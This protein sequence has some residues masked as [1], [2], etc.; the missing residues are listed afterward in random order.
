MLEL[1][2]TKN[3]KNL[4]LQIDAKIPSIG[5]CTLRGFSGSGKSTIL[6]CISGKLN[7][8]S[9]TIKLENTTSF[10]AEKGINHAPY[11]RNFGF[12][13]QDGLLFPNLNVYENLLFGYK[14]RGGNKFIE[15]DEIVEILGIL[16]LLNRNIKNLSGGEKQRIALGRALLSNPKFLLLDE[17]LAALD[18][19]NK[20]QILELI[21]KIRDKVRI[22]MLY[23]THNQSE[24]DL[25]ATSQMAIVNGAMIA[26]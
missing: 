11:L 2:F 5:I 19:A 13:H 3:F 24:A 17:P 21:L 15:F 22:P 23:V 12:V 9:G 6:K 20:A 1:K 25:I 8:D 4:N 18:E 26:V 14:R 16:P 7:P 10:D